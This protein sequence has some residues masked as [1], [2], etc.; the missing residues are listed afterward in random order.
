MHE[1]LFFAGTRWS[2]ARVV[3][4][5]QVV[6]SDPDHRSRKVPFVDTLII[7]T[8]G[9]GRPYE[10]HFAESWWRD[11]AEFALDDERRVVSFLQRR[12]DPSGVLAPGGQ[13]ISTYDWR[14]LKAV[15]E[16]AVV[17]WNPQVD[18]DGV[19]HFRLGNLRSA[20]HMLDMT[21]GEASTG[22]AKETDNYYSGITLMDR[23]L[24]LRAYMVAAAAADVRGGLDMRRCDYCHSWFT[25]HRSDARWCSRSC[26]AASSNQRKSP[27]A[28]VSQD[29]NTQ[30]SDPVAEPLARAGGG[31]PS[32]G[33][34]AELRDPKAG[35]D[36]RRANARDRT[37]R[38]R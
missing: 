37:P 35:G 2:G 38:R 10:V 34:R 1:P 36:A 9:S 29:H 20:E 22:W 26:R 21:I 11:L 3:G 32:A 30:R 8:R 4:R 23:A 27:H 25:L 19:S 13:Q 14:D 24:T 31:R 28:F 7:D 33:P 6:A 15:L 16:R 17:A 12:G 5:K 18:A